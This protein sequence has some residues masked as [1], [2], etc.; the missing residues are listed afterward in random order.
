MVF[1]SLE[2]LFFF[3]PIVLLL[4]YVVP[5]KIKNIVLL[6]ASLI[7]YAWGE[8]VYVFLMIFSSLMGFIF[9]KAIDKSSSETGKKILL[10]L[11]VFVNIAILGFFKYADFAI[12]IIN[13]CLGTSIN[14]LELSLPIG[15]SFFTFQIMSYVIDV[16]RGTAHVQN[17]PLTLMTYVSM[18]PQLIAG[19]IVRYETVEREL[20][21]RTINY[22]GF[23]KGTI[24]FLIGLFKKVLIA[25]NIGQLWDYINNSNF[26]EIS[27]S[28]AW[29]GA[30]AFSIQ[31]YFDFSGYG[32]MAIGMGKMLGFN[33][34]ENFNYPY[35]SKSITEFWRRWHISLSTWFRDYVYIPLG[36]NRCSRLRHIFNILVVWTL[37]GLWHGAS[38]NFV[39]WG[40]YY[41]VL[42]VLE[43][44]VWGKCLD[45]LPRLLKHIYTLFIVVVGFTIFTFDDLSKLKDYLGVMFGLNGMP[46]MDNDF[47]FYCV[48]YGILLISAIIFATPIY[49]KVKEYANSSTHRTA[50]SVFGGVVFCFLFILCVSYLVNASYNPF[51]YFRF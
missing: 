24:R 10:F 51:L 43:K 14:E 42:L 45:K 32:D 20:K 26:E 15:I 7:F 33:F 28:T 16:Y 4:Y 11:S 13:Q 22:E 21:T 17:N 44:Y 36:G 37:T 1:S 6:V 8:P 30:V 48:N 19:P 29:L 34:N 39:F 47:K 41:G 46:L 5:Y 31:L 49:P 18:F 9:G 35:I 50:Y 23:K 3:L 27:V 12:S 38:W 40:A 2:F 25:N